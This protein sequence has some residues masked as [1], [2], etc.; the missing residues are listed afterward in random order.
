[1][2]KTTNGYIAGGYASVS[3]ASYGSYVSDSNAFLFTLTNPSNIPLKLAVTASGNALYDGPSYGPTFGNG[4]DLYISDGSNANTNSYSY[5]SSS[6]TYPNG[7][8]GSNGGVFMLGA[9]N[10][11]VAEVEVFEVKKMDSAIL[12]STSNTN[13][14]NLIGKFF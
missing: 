6:Y 13:L 10:F 11:Q 3:W 5:S 1:M 12:G 4:H 9:S 8:S 7:N 14:L 2:F